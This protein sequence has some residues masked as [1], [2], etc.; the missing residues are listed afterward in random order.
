ML[1]FMARHKIAPQV[2]VMQ[3]S[4]E[5]LQSAFDRL[6]KGDVKYRFVLTH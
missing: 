6:K 2:E 4:E 1:E 3:L 5:N